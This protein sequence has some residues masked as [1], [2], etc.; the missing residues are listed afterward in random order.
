M[1]LILDPAAIEVSKG[2]AGTDTSAPRKTTVQDLINASRS[3]L[4]VS[5]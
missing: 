4:I 2:A 3:A 5:A 1:N